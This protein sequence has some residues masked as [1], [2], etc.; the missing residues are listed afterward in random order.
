MEE[1]SSG[2]EVFPAGG[3][4]LVLNRDVLVT[5]KYTFEERLFFQKSYELI[6]GF[7]FLLLQVISGRRW[8]LPVCHR[9][10]GLP[11]SASG[12]PDV[13]GEEW[14]MHAQH[15]RKPFLHFFLELPDL[16]LCHITKHIVQSHEVDIVHNLGMKRD[17]ERIDLLQLAPGAVFVFLIGIGVLPFLVDELMIP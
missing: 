5:G 2:Y 9:P 11:E 10:I 14:H 13:F 17:V 15:N 12:S 16:F 6:C 1:E 8:K 3:G 4:E 7:V